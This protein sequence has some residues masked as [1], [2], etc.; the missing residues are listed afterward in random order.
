PEDAAE[1]SFAGL[2][3]TYLW[4]KDPAEIIQ[5]VRSCWASLYSV[6]SISY[7]RKLGFP[8]ERVAMAVVVQSMVD[9]R[10]AGVMFTRSPTTGDRS[11]VTI[12]A[13]WGLG[14]A[15]VGGEATPDRWV[16]GKTTGE[17]AVREISDKLIEHVPAA[18]GGVEAVAVAEQRRRTPCLSDAELQEPRPLARRTA[19]RGKGAETATA[20]DARPAP[21]VADGPAGAGRKPRGELPATAAC[22]V[23]VTAPFVGI[24]H[25]APKPG[26]PP[27]IE[28]GSEV[29]EDTIIGIIEVMKL[30]NAVRA[31][32]RGTVVE[33]L[34]ADGAV[35]E[36]GQALVRVSRGTQR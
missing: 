33:I 14:S 17:I 27:Y 21:T 34:V 11:V 32:A 1:A 13:A 29:Q 23:Q 7:R 20:P 5:R 8:E 31:E 22:V 3:D 16:L 4:I 6:E 25:R 26:A 9:A 28:V 2:Q 18:R 36:Y 35:V 15:V 30:M 19:P 24:F 10:T 12:E